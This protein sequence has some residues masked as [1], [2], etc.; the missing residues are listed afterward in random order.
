MRK[1]D[2]YGTKALYLLSEVL[3]FKTAI[4]RKTNEKWTSV[5]ANKLKFSEN[6]NS[7]IRNLAHFLIISS[8]YTE[9]FVLQF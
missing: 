1:G 2:G 3:R 5:K 8:R 9:P 6:K 4:V 7:V